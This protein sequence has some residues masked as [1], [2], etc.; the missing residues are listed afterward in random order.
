MRRRKA[1]GVAPENPCP[2]EYRVSGLI[3]EPLVIMPVATDN[4]ETL[5]TLLHGSVAV[6]GEGL[7]G[8][9]WKPVHNRK[10]RRADQT[11][12]I[13]LTHQHTTYS[14]LTLYKLAGCEFQARRNTSGTPG[15]IKLVA[16]FSPR[17]APGHR[18][19]RE[20]K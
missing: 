17:P 13:R 2:T 12:P 1:A 4:V 14:V 18:E 9:D 20:D 19:V 7:I 11:L 3:G 5:T 6:A 10:L 15:L 8:T 16:R